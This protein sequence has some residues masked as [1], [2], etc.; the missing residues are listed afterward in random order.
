M[1]ADLGRREVVQAA[2]RRRPSL[3]S[4][5]LRSRASGTRAWAVLPSGFSVE[6]SGSAETPPDP[7]ACGSHGLPCSFLVFDNFGSKDFLP[8]LGRICFISPKFRNGVFKSLNVCLFIYL[9]LAFK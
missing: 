1:P 6:E 4:S 8:S 2:G 9:F 7:S 5:G 3:S